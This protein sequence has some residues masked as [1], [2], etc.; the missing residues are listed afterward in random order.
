MRSTCPNLR[1]HFWDP[2][3]RLSHQ[4]DIGFSVDGP[5]S[6]WDNLSGAPVTNGGAG[7]SL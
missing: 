6:N 5:G 2:E 7:G 3:F 4:R 1:S